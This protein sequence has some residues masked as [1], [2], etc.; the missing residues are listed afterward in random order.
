M[1]IDEP[2]TVDIVAARPDSNVVQLVIVDHLAWDD[3]DA[4]TRQLQAKINTYIA[5]VESGQLSR[6]KEPPIP[7][8]PIVRI[9][10]AAQHAPPDAAAEFLDRA[11]AFL[12]RM[13]IGLEVKV[14]HERK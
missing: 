8:L 13:E 2:D 14:Q 7:R 1:S 4:H 9:V 11:R 6:L 12:A 5:F 3:L 10:I